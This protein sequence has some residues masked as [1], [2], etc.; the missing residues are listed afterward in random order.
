MISSNANNE[1]S[2]DDLSNS[3]IFLPNIL[4]EFDSSTYNLKLFMVSPE[5]VKTRTMLDV[6]KQEVIAES[7]VTGD[8]YIEDFEIQSVPGMTKSVHTGTSTKLSFKLHQVLGADLIDRIYRIADS[9]GIDNYTKIPYYLQLRFKGRT[10]DESVD[11]ASLSSNIWLWPIII[12][13]VDIKVDAASSIYDM[14]GS[15]YN[16]LAY[17]NEFS[18]IDK[19]LQ[20]SAATVNEYFN[21]PNGLAQKMT[22]R[23]K[24]RQTSGQDSSDEWVFDFDDDIKYASIVASDPDKNSIRNG[25]FSSSDSDKTL[26]QF[27]DGTDILRAIDAILSNT[28]L[29]Q[30][31]VKNTSTPDTLPNSSDDKQLATFKKL[32]RVYSEVEIL[33]YDKLRGDYARKFSYYVKFYDIPSVVGDVETEQDNVSSQIKLLEYLKKGYLKKRYDYIY[34]GLNNQ[35]LNFDMNFNFAWYANKAKQ[36]GTQTDASQ[37]EQNQ[38]KI[39][40]P[41]EQ[42]EIKTQGATRSLKAKIATKTDANNSDPANS[43][44]AIPITAIENEMYQ[45]TAGYGIESKAGPGRNILS[46]LFNQSTGS[47]MIKIELK[48]KGDPYWLEPAPRVRSEKIGNLKEELN[49]EAEKKNSAVF[50]KEGEIFILFSSQTPSLSTTLGTNTSLHKNSAINGLYRVIIIS[51]TFANGHFTQVLT[52]VRDMTIDTSKTDIL[53]RF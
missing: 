32:Y 23:Q 26:V 33:S 24:E 18:N 46:S 9:L 35:I 21:G 51:S 38:G 31:K 4:D 13:K 22:E 1:L 39:Q 34:T 45:D 15:I 19:S 14:S 17:T 28:S 41:A 7:G 43:V 50:T 2:A 53:T 10:V 16:D 8:V 27:N 42:E 20:I 37:V 6:D 3:K 52:C 40:K 11:S 48:I 12:S 5:T 25:D 44:G 49:R 30:K 36:A 29:F 47:D